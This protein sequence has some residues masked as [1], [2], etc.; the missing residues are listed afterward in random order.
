MFGNNPIRKEIKDAII[1]IKEILGN[2]RNPISAADI[3]HTYDDKYSIAAWSTSLSCIGLLN[4]LEMIGVTPDILEKYRQHHVNGK[5]VNMQFYNKPSATFLRKEEKQ[6]DSGTTKV[7]ETTNFL[8]NKSTKTKKI[9]HTITEYYW[10]VVDEWKITLFVGSDSTNEETT[11]FSRAEGTYELKV[12]GS[13][14]NPIKHFREGVKK[15]KMNF[16]LNLLNGEKGQLEFKIDRSKDSCRTPRRN[17]DVKTAFVFMNEFRQFFQYVYTNLQSTTRIESDKVHDN[18]KDLYSIIQNESVKKAL[19]TGPIMERDGENRLGIMMKM[20][21]VHSILMQHTK[22][23]T[24]VISKIESI[25]QDEEK[26]IYNKL[27]TSYEAKTMFIALHLTVIAKRWMDTMQDIENM[28][29]KQLRDAVGKE[30]STTSFNEYMRFHNQKMYNEENLPKPF[31][32]AIRRPDHYPEGELSIE[33]PS[34]MT[35]A[36]MLSSVRKAMNPHMMHFPLNAATNIQ[37]SGDRYLHACVNNQFGSSPG[38]I[39]N[40]QFSIH[41]RARQFS[42]FILMI[43]TVP[44]AKKFDVKH[45]IIIKDKDELQIPLSMETIPTAKEFKE[46]ISSISPE[47]QRFAKAYR[48]MQLSSTLFAIAVVQ[49]KP[50]LEKLLNLPNDSLTKEIQ[51]TQDLMKLFIKYQIP[52]DLISYD[53]NN[54]VNYATSESKMDEGIVTNGNAN[55][56]LN[57]VKGHVEKM[58]NMIADLKEQ[59]IKRKAEV[60]IAA[61]LDRQSYKKQKVRARGRRS[62]IESSDDE[63]EEEDFI[64]ESGMHGMAMGAAFGGGGRMNM[65]GGPPPPPQAAMMKRRQ[66]QGGGLFGGA[67]TMKGGQ[68]QGGGLFGGTN[69]NVGQGGNEA[70]Q[71]SEDL[72]SG[73]MDN[74]NQS[75]ENNTTNVED[76]TLLP[77]LLEKRCTEI[78]PTAKL[79]PTIIK[80]SSGWKK[81]YKE[82]ILSPLASTTLLDSQT[83]EEKN[84]AFDL[85]DALSKS[86]SISLD[87]VDLHIVIASTH[88]FDKTVVDTVIQNN[89][90]PIEQLERS[91]LIMSSTIQNKNI[92]NL[93]KN[94]EINRIKKVSPMLFPSLTNE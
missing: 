66:G 60:A 48:K 50:Q 92:L 38:K 22:D 64:Q 31:C 44:T 2:T 90:N 58:N 93:I 13:E 86:G 6:V 70:G 7:E 67:A 57:Q 37:F 25:T 88:C 94:S 52:S 23:L 89:D 79:R 39:T 4:T 75:I 71:T 91:L 3:E 34:G 8:G 83:K 17:E 19:P 62:K 16:L 59:D 63:D 43:G 55:I 82:S 15:L 87:A 11:I 18:M 53:Q 12:V 81:N 41:A 85:L 54:V 5:V 24:N 36:H 45:A 68:G 27:M 26:Y 21:D 80:V 29:Y 47:Q 77:S 51:L 72:Q 28:L 65:R 42:S 46:A 49:I 78:D 74:N 40:N 69:Q 84:K 76:Y 20:E 10:K 61:T 30:I 33:Y 1:K 32:Y 73:D 56:A 35:K 9:V 14:N